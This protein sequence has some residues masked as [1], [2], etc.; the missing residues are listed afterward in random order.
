MADAFFLD[1]A[2]CRP[3][4]LTARVKKKGGR[5]RDNKFPNIPNCKCGSTRNF[6]FQL[7][8][9]LLYL[10]DVDKYYKQDSS[11]EKVLNKDEGGMNWGVI[12]VYSCSNSCKQSAEEFIVIQE[13]VDANPQKIVV[14]IPPDD[15]NKDD[16]SMDD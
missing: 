2:S 9:S 13:S 7:M 4:P 12:A 5:C 10:L 1:Y 15:A 3:T 6:E 16:D 8:P 11:L 14:A